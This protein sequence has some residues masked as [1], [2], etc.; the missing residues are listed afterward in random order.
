MGGPGPRGETLS[1]F[2]G[3]V[4]AETDEP[5]ALE[6]FYATVFDVDQQRNDVRHRE[7]LCVNDDEIDEYRLSPDGTTL[8]VEHH[9][10]VRCDGSPGGNSTVF[11]SSSAGFE[12]DNPT[13][14]Q[15]LG[16]VQDQRPNALDFVA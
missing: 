14:P 5:V 3:F 4:D 7:R 10:G 13:D 9:V 12:C 2:V 1:A 16:L 15:N 11:A 6:R 8:E